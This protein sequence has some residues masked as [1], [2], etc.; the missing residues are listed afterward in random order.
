[1]IRSGSGSL[2]SVS[3]FTD[4]LRASSLEMF[5]CAKGTSISWVLILR[6]GFKEAKGS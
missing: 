4:L 2:T 6:L 5:S 3:I 1:M